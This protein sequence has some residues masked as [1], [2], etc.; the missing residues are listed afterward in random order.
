MRVV[1]RREILND[2]KLQ[3]LFNISVH[4]YSQNEFMACPIRNIARFIIQIFIFNDIQCS[5]KLHITR[6]Y[7]FFPEVVVG[8]VVYGVAWRKAQYLTVNTATYKHSSMN[9]NYPVN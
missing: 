7:I 2:P 1:F 8:Y 5:S 3:E 6:T 4:S 9:K